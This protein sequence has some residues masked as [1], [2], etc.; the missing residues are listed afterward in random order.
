MV[1]DEENGVHDG[2]KILGHLGKLFSGIAEVIEQVLQRL[3]VLI[4]LI[5]LLLSDLNL[6]LQLG[7]GGCVGTF[8]LF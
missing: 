7:E 2:D 5:G 6:F 4:V 8:I 1:P 3:Q